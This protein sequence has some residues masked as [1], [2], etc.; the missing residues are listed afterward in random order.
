MCSF[1]HRWRLTSQRRPLSTSESKVHGRL[2][3][4]A[5]L[6]AAV[7]VLAGSGVA[8]AYAVAYRQEYAVLARDSRVTAEQQIAVLKSEFDKQHSVPAI[9]A[10]DAGV[11]SAVT[12]PTADK[13]VAISEKLERLQRETNSTDIYILDK[14]G[15]TLSA[16]NYASPTSFVG[17]NYHFRRYFSDAIHY[18]EGQQFALGTVSR[19][20]GLYIARRISVAGRPVGVVVVKVEFDAIEASWRRP[21]AATFVTNASNDVLLSSIPELRF[22]QIPSPV[23]SQFVITLPTQIGAWRLSLFNSLKDA[24]KAARTAALVATLAECLLG[25]LLAWWWRRRRLAE[26]RTAAERRYREDL[27]REVA[28]RTAELSEANDRLSREMIERQQA[29]GRLNV[30][31]EELVQANK[32]A[33]LGQITAGVAHEIN[34]PLAA[35]RALAE[36]CI[37][38]LEKNSTKRPTGAVE[39][40][41]AG[42]VR[43]NERIGHITSELKAF[44]RKGTSHAEPVSLK[45]TL[46]S[47][48]LLSRSKGNKVRLIREAVD[49]RIKVIGGRIRLEQALVNLLQNAYEA[50]ESTERP[51]V[52]IAATMDEDWVFLKI[53]DNGPGLAPQVLSQIFTPFVTTKETGLGLGLVIAHDIVRD[54]GGELTVDNGPVG[55]TFTVKLR[56]VAPEPQP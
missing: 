33:Q 32:L 39:Q 22:Q 34:Q 54:F 16:S 25:T 51:E 13:S 47:A 38:M 10:E 17:S 46:N 9:L 29:E 28:S 4:S 41:L 45:N 5:K 50:L 1:S 11:I 36:N 53:S 30:L 24:N 55:A 37:T 52:R 26:E 35:M 2:P 7:F 23:P 3:V 21:D 15:T 12:Q 18:G 49:G 48:L 42:I 14:D 44:S 31:Q 43:L 8:G 27:Q 56:K 6:A 40:N 19:R 20:P